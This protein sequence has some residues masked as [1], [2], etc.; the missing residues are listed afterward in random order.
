VTTITVADALA[1]KRN[2]VRIL[3]RLDDGEEAVAQEEFKLRWRRFLACLNL[4]QFCR[5]LR[6]WAASEAV[7]GEAPELP[8]LA[9]APAPAISDRWSEVAQEVT[10]KLRSLVEDLATRGVAT[11]EVERYNE[12]IDDD[13]FAEL[14]WPEASPPVALLAGDQADFKD[15]WTSGGWTVVTDRDLL[16]GVDVLTRHLV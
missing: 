11:P 13:A 12:L 16:D 7:S 9:L 10:P 4:F 8:G 15:R 6:F 14:A 2:E 3:A 1:T 5:G